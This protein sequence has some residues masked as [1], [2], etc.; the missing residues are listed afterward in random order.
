MVEIRDPCF[1][2]GCHQFTSPHPWLDLRL[3]FV[4]RAAAGDAAEI[5]AQM[6]RAR[7][8]RWISTAILRCRQGNERRHQSMSW[9]LHVSQGEERADGSSFYYHL[10]PLTII[11]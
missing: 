11:Y 4:G 9:P 10:P 2:P 7:Y 5:T 1:V 6:T 3:I 8:R